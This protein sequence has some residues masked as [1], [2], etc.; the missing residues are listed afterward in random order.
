MN[1]KPRTN[2]SAVFF[3]IISAILLLPALTAFGWFGITRIRTTETSHI[4]PGELKIKRGEESCLVTIPSGELSITY[5]K[6]TML[7]S[8]SPM[9]VEAV[10]SEPVLITEQTP[11]AA[12]WLAHLE[13]QTSI[14][15]GSLTPSVAQTQPFFD[16]TDL[17]YHW[18]FTPETELMPY[19]AQLW[20][21]V[22]VT[23]GIDTVERW[24]LLVREFPT[25]IQS[26][27]GQ[28]ADV[29][30]LAAGVCALIGTLCGI[31]GV[32]KSHRERK[33]Q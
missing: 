27:F 1:T 16:R 19:K 13:V 12:K 28:K 6:R 25:G 31:L 11:G 24:N 29:V 5:P 8:S 7:G 22:I 2:K 4:L 9:D 21:H 33:K 30:L 32:Q 10:F 26:Y 18:D 20:L 15:G 3:K 23:D 17:K 14:A